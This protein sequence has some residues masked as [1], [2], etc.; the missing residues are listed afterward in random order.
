MLG[1]IKYTVLVV[2]FVIS[3]IWVIVALSM[4]NPC[5]FDTSD[6]PLKVTENFPTIGLMILITGPVY[7]YWGFLLS[8]LV[9][10]NKILVTLASSVVFFIIFTYFFLFRQF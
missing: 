7:I 1:I 6:C 9:K 5:Q 3:L 10:S 2:V 4:F 8:K